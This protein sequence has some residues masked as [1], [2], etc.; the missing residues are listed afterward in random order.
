MYTPYEAIQRNTRVRRTRFT[1]VRWKTQ[2]AL[3]KHIYLPK[4]VR[5]L[6]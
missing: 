5:L 6:K 3:K 4:G 2:G 1:L